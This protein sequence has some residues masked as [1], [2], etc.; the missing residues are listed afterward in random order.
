MENDKL[1][2]AYATAIF[3]GIGALVVSLI[4]TGVAAVPAGAF[5]LEHVVLGLIIR[6][7]YKAFDGESG[8]YVIANPV[9]AYFEAGAQEATDAP[10]NGLPA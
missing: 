10:T 2:A 6:G 1:F 9:R 3:L 7:S 8:L 5:M 4:Y